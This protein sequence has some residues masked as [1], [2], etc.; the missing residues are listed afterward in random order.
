MEINLLKERGLHRLQK[1]V[2]IV[3]SKGKSM[4]KIKNNNPQHIHYFWFYVLLR[5]NYLNYQDIKSNIGGQ[6]Y[7]FIL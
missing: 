4:L 7:L 5:V 2:E 6:I 3:F 1:T